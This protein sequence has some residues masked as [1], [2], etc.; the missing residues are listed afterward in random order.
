MGEVYS[1][2]VMS[3]SAGSSLSLSSETAKTLSGST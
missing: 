2:D 3:E 1:S